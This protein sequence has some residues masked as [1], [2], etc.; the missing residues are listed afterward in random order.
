M[1]LH[2]AFALSVGTTFQGTIDAWQSADKVASSSQ[3]NVC[4]TIGNVFKLSDVVMVEDNSSLTSSPDFVLSTDNLFD[5]L[6]MCQR[7]YEKSYALDVAPITANY[8]TALA[9]SF[10]NGNN[11]W[12]GFDSITC[13][14]KTN[15]RISTP[16]VTTMNGVTLGSNA[17]EYYL[18]AS[19]P[20]NGTSGGY[21]SSDGYFKV[22]G[23]YTGTG[24][25]NTVNELRFHYTAD[26]EL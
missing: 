15:K 22:S 19:G 2:V 11:A 1:G 10:Q 26:A 8:S 12:D 23:N 25:N 20:F 16:V 14:F 3:V 6:R 17:I 7:Y 4:D 13:N 21:T 5:E 18:S 9:P 24:S